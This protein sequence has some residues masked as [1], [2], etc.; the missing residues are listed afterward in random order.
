MSKRCALKRIILPRP[1]SCVSSSKQQAG[2]DVQTRNGSSSTSRSGSVG[3]RPRA[4][5][6]DACPLRTRSWSYSGRRAAETTRGAVSLRGKRH[7]GNPRRRPTSVSTRPPSGA[8]EIRFLGHASDPAFM[9][10][11][12]ERE[13]YVPRDGAARRLEEATTTLTVVLCPT[14]SD[15][16]SRRSPAWRDGRW[17]CRAPAA[18]R[19]AWRAPTPSASGVSDGARAGAGSDESQSR[20]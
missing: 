12:I 14:R 5:R 7:L 6:A 8:C 13:A 4:A 16:D 11:R 20:G 15:R 9:R 17:P 18:R 3:A 1:A 2:V 10:H 19:S